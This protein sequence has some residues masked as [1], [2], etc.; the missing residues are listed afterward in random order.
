MFTL[1][2]IIKYSFVI[3]ILRCALLQFLAAMV[4]S[5]IMLRLS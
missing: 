3:F 1:K 5:W 4:L 2:K